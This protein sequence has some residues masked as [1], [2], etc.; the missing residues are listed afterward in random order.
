MTQPAPRPFEI[1]S[2][3]RGDESGRFLIPILPPPVP[4]PVPVAKAP[5]RVESFWP[6]QVEQPAA[7]ERA[8]LIIEDLSLRLDNPFAR[9]SL[10]PPPAKPFPTRQVLACVAAFATAI[11]TGA[12]LS[13][14][15][16]AHPAEV[17]ARTQTTP[18]SSIGQTRPALVPTTTPD[19]APA[20][21]SALSSAV[22]VPVQA[23]APVKA[24][25]VMPAKSSA[26]TQANGARTP[27]RA[28]TVEHSAQAV[29]VAAPPTSSMPDLQPEAAAAATV[30]GAVPAPSEQAAATASEEAVAVPA[31]AAAEALAAAPAATPTS[32]GLDPLPEAPTRDEIKAAFEA[33]RSELTTCAAGSQGTA[34]LHVTIT[35]PTGRATYSIV[36]GAFAGTPEGSC[37]AR[38]ARAASFP[39]FAQ[40]TLKASYPF[41]L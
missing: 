21:Q 12:Y 35:G 24:A 30:S 2:L 4:V 3:D 37:M 15:P 39:R 20:A 31:P 19:V 38:A 22:V 36:E 5:S 23:T 13:T 8:E 6:A 41:A 16:A 34:L 32:E 29:K 28:A 33:L 26:A 1:D 9:S 10:L 17:A 11:V 7:V 40:P 18:A 14:R 27:A 25:P